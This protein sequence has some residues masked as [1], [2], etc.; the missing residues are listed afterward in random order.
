MDEYDPEP[1]G[2]LDP[3]AH[4]R[5]TE[6]GDR[7]DL[8]QNG[9]AAEHSQLSATPKD[10]TRESPTVDSDNSV[11]S[12]VES[13][14]GA[15]GADSTGVR[16][17]KVAAVATAVAGLLLALAVLNKDLEGPKWLEIIFAGVAVIALCTA[18]VAAI[19]GRVDE[20][21][22]AV[23]PTK[24]ARGV[25][26]EPRHVPATR[27]TGARGSVGDRD[28][29][30]VS[31][32]EPHQALGRAA[33]IADGS[34]A[35]AS[36]ATM[37]GRFRLPPI[38]NFLKTVAGII[39]AGFVGAFF[40]DNPKLIPV[41]GP[42]AGHGHT[43]PAYFAG[44]I[45]QPAGA[46][47]Y[48]LARLGHRVV[49]HGFAAQLSIAGYCIGQATR[50]SLGAF[51]ERW[52]ILRDGRVIPYPQVRV[53][54]GVMPLKRCPGAPAGS[55]GGPTSVALHEQPGRTTLLRAISSQA[56]TIGFAIYPPAGKHWQTLGLQL[57]RRHEFSVGIPVGGAAVAIAVP[58]WA[59]KVPANPEQSS[60]PLY[61][62]LAL[63]QKPGPVY[64]D[65]IESIRSG[66]AEACSR[67]VYGAVNVGRRSS[68]RSK[69]QSRQTSMPLTPE[70]SIESIDRSK[71]YERPTVEGG[72]SGEASAPSQRKG[73]LKGT[74]KKEV[75]E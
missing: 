31:A 6:V 35:R 26:R 51:D 63:G 32:A 56:T 65:A 11:G 45:I 33:A 46:W 73:G 27:R 30:M 40:V 3:Q 25:Q 58:C 67:S 74:G 28:S 48:A 62:V 34:G 23:S 37:P 68:Q 41:F 16:W 5:G 70:R 12:G 10:S 4:A 66:I 64:A 36:T 59:P 21:G 60:L 17:R 24:P 47:E 53:S 39:L 50:N 49:H 18:L 75:V 29:D 71:H 14:N 2:V 22:A 7:R 13:N 72:G 69:S 54:G 43:R 44:T 52:V 55:I 42:S 57:E 38:P 61:S 19:R 9:S 1:G 20:P 8:P 15:G